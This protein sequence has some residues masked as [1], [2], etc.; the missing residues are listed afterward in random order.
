MNYLAVL[1]LV[2]G[3]IFIYF[4]MSL[5]CSTFQELLANVLNLRARYLNQ[6]MH[7]TFRKNSLGEKILAH[8]LVDGLTAKGRKASYIPADVFS[9]VVLDLIHR[10]DHRP[11]SAASLKD[12]IADTSLLTDD[13]KQKLLQVLTESGGQIAVV[14]EAIET[15]FDQAMERVSGTYKKVAQRT[16]LVF[17]MLSASVLNVDSI[18]IVRYLYDHPV[19]AS[20]LA[21]QI[22]SFIARENASA[23]RSAAETKTSQQTLAELRAIQ[24]RL[25]ETHL[26]M[27]WEQQPPLSAAGVITKCLGLLLTAFAALL[28]APFWFE[29]LNKLTNLRSAGNKPKTQQAAQK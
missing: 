19:K 5:F 14:R 2:I 22:S 20:A 16:M 27:G 6:W 23:N 3:L 8:T 10:T 29:L 21:D 18:A 7:D 9:H 4:L 17:A 24:H 13:L 11:Y 12:A 1:D 28:G 15:W 25:A 26:P